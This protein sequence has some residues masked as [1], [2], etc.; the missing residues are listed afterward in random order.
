MFLVCRIGS[1]L[2]VNN[3][4]RSDVIVVLGGDHND[5]RYHRGLALIQR[6]EGERL[7]VDANSDEVQFGETLTV[8]T[9]R[10]I[11]RTAGTLSDR[12]RVCRIE[13]DSTERETEYVAQCLRQLGVGR[14]L[15]VTSSFHT[16]RAL[17]IFRVR[18]PH[19]RW[20]VTGVEDGARFGES[21]WQNRE[22]A[23]TTFMEWT[24]MLW[25]EGVDRW[26][27]RPDPM[28]R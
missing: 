24:K 26:R 12:I 27:R 22:W 25:W 4:E 28:T 2:V 15:L 18:L 5:I 23:K 3:P 7:L 10:F 6:G 19:Y 11:Q 17:S 9:E 13:G 16:R 21:W 20:S 1:F 14:V 8:Q